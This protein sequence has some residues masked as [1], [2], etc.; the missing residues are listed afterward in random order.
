ML[1]A[2]QIAFHCVRFVFTCRTLL[3]EEAGLIRWISVR[4]GMG[5][6]AAGSSST[7]RGINGGNAPRAVPGHGTVH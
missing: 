2:F 7:V 4:D 3:E 5:N 6:L 1:F